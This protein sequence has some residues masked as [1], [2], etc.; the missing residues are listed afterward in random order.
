MSV[1]ICIQ[2]SVNSCYTVLKA[3]YQKNVGSNETK[4]LA[5]PVLKSAA[6][7]RITLEIPAAKSRSHSQT[8]IDKR[9]RSYYML[10]WWMVRRLCFSYAGSAL[11]FERGLWTKSQLYFNWR[12]SNSLKFVIGATKLAKK[13]V[14]FHSR[15]SSRSHHTHILWNLRLWHNVRLVDFKVK[16][17][18]SGHL[19]LFYSIAPDTFVKSKK[20][21]VWELQ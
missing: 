2:S 18:Y 21:S 6:L 12:R 17:I 16:L 4:L 13:T 11:P 19:T 5:P 8:K 15:S 10:L 1:C 3:P 7:R 14:S 9:I 20:L